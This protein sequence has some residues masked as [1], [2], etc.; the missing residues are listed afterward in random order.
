MKKLKEKEDSYFET[1]DISLA[2]TLYYFGFKIES[3]NKNNPTRA[4]FIFDKS[5][6]L[7]ALTQGF[8][9][10]SLQVEPLAFLNSLKEVKTRLYQQVG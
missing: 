5:K 6:E 3:I 10:H 4:V 1:T 9:S 2:N 7:D 8:W